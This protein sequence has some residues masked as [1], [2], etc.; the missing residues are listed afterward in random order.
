MNEPDLR[1]VV[2]Q[3]WAAARRA[4]PGPTVAYFERL[5]DGHAGNATAL[6]HCARAH[7]FAGEPYLAAP[8][9]Q[10]AIEAGLSGVP[11]R[12]CLASYGSAL[13][14]LDRFAESVQILEMAH[15]Q[16]PDDALIMCY[17]ALSLH[18]AGESAR[19]LS[20]LLDL[21]LAKIEQPDLVANRW[22]LGNYAAAL[23]LGSWAADGAASLELTGPLLSAASVDRTPTF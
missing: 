17:L 22:A 4:D 5:L 18:S 9:Y 20:L 8:L 16:F 10:R 14:N 6:L 2:R 12:R 23:E 11:L 1:A 15:R 3:G 13:R 21:A 19:A 7:D